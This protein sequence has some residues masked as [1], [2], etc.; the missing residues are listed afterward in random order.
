MA[1]ILAVRHKSTAAILALIAFAVLFVISLVSFGQGA[2]IGW[3][4]TNVGDINSYALITGGV[5]AAAAPSTWRR[6]F[7]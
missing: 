7:C 5:G 3:L 1:I 4:A 2:L 6:S